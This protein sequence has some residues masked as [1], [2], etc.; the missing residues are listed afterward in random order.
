MVLHVQ[1]MTQN[2]ALQL[3]TLTGII[4][5][6]HQSFK[7]LTDFRFTV[8]TGIHFNVIYIILYIPTVKNGVSDPKDRIYFPNLI[9]CYR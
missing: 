3:Y 5:Y 7:R 6:W 2:A 8:Y 9:W 4:P 1:C